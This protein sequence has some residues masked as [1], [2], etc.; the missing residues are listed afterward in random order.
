[1]AGRYRGPLH[2]IPWGAKDLLAVRGYPTTWGARPFEEQE[3]PVDAAVVERLDRAGAVLV[4][5]LT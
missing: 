5:K 2:G 1:E 4:A 3:I